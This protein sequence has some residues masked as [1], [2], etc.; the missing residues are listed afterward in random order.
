[1]IYTIILNAIQVFIKSPVR[2]P[3]TSKQRRRQR[4]RADGSLRIGWMPYATVHQGFSEHLA[5]PVEA[6]NAG[7]RIF[8]LAFLYVHLHCP[9]SASGL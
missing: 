5:R 4:N 2:W 6:A 7:P 3:I 8:P 1:M 9:S